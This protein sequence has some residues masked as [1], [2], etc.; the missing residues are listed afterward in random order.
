MLKK[1]LDE[2]DLN[3]YLM[4]YRNNPISGLSYLPAQ[5]LQSRRLRTLL[6][7]FNEKCLKPL[8]VDA[9]E[10]MG[11]S[12]ERQ[13]TYYNKNS[14]KV[15]S[16]FYLGEK[17]LIQNKLSYTW[18]PGV[19]IEKTKFPRSYIKN[20]KGRLLRGNTSFLKK[21]DQGTEEDKYDNNKSNKIPN[22]KS[23]S[24]FGHNIK[25][26]KRYGFDD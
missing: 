7:N 21:A 11:E 23:T 3:L 24:I 19:I 10:E 22:N 17:I 8:V 4:N 9:S 13:I 18:L 2:G 16:K 1:A 20:E 5:L 12:K 6:D 14:G 15:E 25:K 26:P